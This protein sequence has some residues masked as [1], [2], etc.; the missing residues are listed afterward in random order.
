LPNPNAATELD[1]NAEFD[2][3]NVDPKKVLVVY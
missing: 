1:Y 3:P 2:Y